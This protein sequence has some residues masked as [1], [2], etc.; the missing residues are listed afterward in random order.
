MI[1]SEVKI[2]YYLK[3]VELYPWDV[4]NVKNIDTTGK[5]AEDIWHVEWG[6]KEIQITCG[7]IAPM[8]ANIQTIKKNIQHFQGLIECAIE[9][10][11]E[12]KWKLWR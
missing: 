4:L 1:L 6:A 5:P 2:G 10:A 7:K 8:K 3:R 12:K 9:C 11:I